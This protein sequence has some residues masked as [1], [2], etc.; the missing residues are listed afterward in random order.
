[1]LLHPFG[2]GAGVF[3][4]LRMSSAQ[5]VPGKTLYFAHSGQL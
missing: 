2:P 3:V 4:Q 1:M 5:I